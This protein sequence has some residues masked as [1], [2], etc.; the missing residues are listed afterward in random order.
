M[1]LQRYVIVGPRTAGVDR[2][3]VEINMFVGMSLL[4]IYRI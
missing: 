2:L 1:K 4:D 3:H